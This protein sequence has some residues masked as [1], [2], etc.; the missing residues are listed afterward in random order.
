M[1]I[2]LSKTCAAKSAAKIDTFFELHNTFPTL[3]SDFFADCMSNPDV[4]QGAFPTRESALMMSPDGLMLSISVR[5]KTLKFH[6]HLNIN[7]VMALLHGVA[8]F[9]AR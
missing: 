6:K 2:R 3:F 4:N 8:Y 9:E 1:S 5:Q 7:A